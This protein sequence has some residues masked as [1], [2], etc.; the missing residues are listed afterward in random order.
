MSHREDG[1]VVTKKKIEVKKPR[2]FKVVFL[3]DDYT[4]MDF[5]CRVLE[6]V[7]HKSPAESASIMLNVHNSGAGIAGIYTKEVAETKLEQTL[8]WARQEGHPLALSMEPE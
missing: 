2:R 3:N 6:N 1:E 7:F 4:P 8:K 5:V